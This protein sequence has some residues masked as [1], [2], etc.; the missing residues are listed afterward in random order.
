MSTPVDH[1]WLWS[2]MFNYK[3]LWL[4]MIGYDMFL[5]S[6]F[7]DHVWLWYVPYVWPCLTSVCSL[8][9]IMA[10]H[11]I[12]WLNYV[13]FLHSSM[14]VSKCDFHQGFCDIVTFL[15]G[16]VWL[17]CSP[18]SISHCDS[19]FYLKLICSF[20]VTSHLTFIKSYFTLWHSLRVMFQCE[21]H[22]WS[23]CIVIFILLILY[24]ISMFLNGYV[25]SEN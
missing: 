16:Y 15:Q 5:I 13:E 17:W 14:V 24:E 7:Y 3:W 20:M 23:W 21:V 9:L 25:T 11:V 1:Y 10:N 8:C 4:S 12:S 18:M 19:M 6:N 22:K 2:T